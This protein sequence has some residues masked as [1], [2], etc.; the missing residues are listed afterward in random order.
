MTKIFQSRLCRCIMLVLAIALS[1][2]NAKADPLAGSKANEHVTIGAIIPL[3]GSQA[4]YGIEASRLF[5]LLSEGD[6]Y[7]EGG[8]RFKF[9]VEDGKCGVGSAPI[10]AAKKLVLVDKTKFLIAGCS[11]E[12]LQVAPFTQKQ[13]AILFGYIS[14]HRDVKH[15]GD[16]V[17]RSFYDLGSAGATVEDKLTELGLS[18]L[19]VVTE[20]VSFTLGI[21]DVLRDTIGTKVIAKEDYPL[22]SP[23]FRGIATRIKQRGADSVFINAAAPHSYIQLYNELRK[24]GFT[25]PVF[26]YYQAGNREVMN[27][28]GA[29]QDNVWYLSA[30]KPSGN[31]PRFINI[32]ERYIKRFGADINS[33]FQLAVVYDALQSI[34]DAV[35]AVGDD[36]VKVRDYLGSYSAPGASGQIEYDVNG[37]I[38]N[39]KPVL[40]KIEQGRA[41]WPE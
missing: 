12:V 13:R 7:Q 23:D 9:L 8:V 16:L 29:A 5:Q 33:E 22:D 21:K 28:L 11:G 25:G 17:Y 35:V 4:V 6:G 31:S 2:S 15:A 27:A 36:P 37:D 14:G 40:I 24:M 39:V 34:V 26:S 10:T 18:K 41:I 30:P 32:R 19:A 1:S 38:K 3:S 20:E